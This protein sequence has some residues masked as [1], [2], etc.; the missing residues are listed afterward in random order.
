MNVSQGYEEFKN[1]I[2][3]IVIYLEIQKNSKNDVVGI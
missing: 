1:T 2:S 3:E